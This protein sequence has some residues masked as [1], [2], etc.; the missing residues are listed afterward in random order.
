MP[1]QVMGEVI[2]IKKVGAYLHLTIVAPG[3]AESFRPGHFV[4]LAVGGEG[5]AA[6]V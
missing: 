6:A 3:V 5:V 2:S 1:V 4:A